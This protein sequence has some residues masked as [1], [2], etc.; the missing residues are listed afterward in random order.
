MFCFFFLSI[1]SLVRGV[2]RFRREGLG[3]WCGVIE[4]SE[5]EGVIVFGLG[6]I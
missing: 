4:D 5:E 3:L 6:G 2:R 1:Y